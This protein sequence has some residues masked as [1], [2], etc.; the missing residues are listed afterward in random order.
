M[1]L[2]VTGPPIPRGFES[3]DLAR[4]A[5]FMFTRFN[6]ELAALALRQTLFESDD[7]DPDRHVLHR[8][9][10]QSMTMLMRCRYSLINFC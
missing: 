1:I 6:A 10:R 3:G 4:V 5:V 7:S 8:Y 9:C 2:L